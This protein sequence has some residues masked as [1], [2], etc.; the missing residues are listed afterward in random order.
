MAL[1]EEYRQA[2][3]KLTVSQVPIDSLWKAPSPGIIKINFDCAKLGDWGVGW[4]VAARDSGG[5]LLW[6]TM[7]QGIGLCGAEYEESR[8]CLLAC[9]EAV[10]RGMQCILL[11]GDCSNLITKLKNRSCPNTKLGLLI[12]H[13]LQVLSS[14]QFYD[15]VFVKRGGNKVAL[16]DPSPTCRSI[17]SKVG[18]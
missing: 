12:S 3:D 5:S 17:L 13:I 2:Q 1:V 4:G 14:V 6:S 7:R 16:S 8:S 18:R 11:E 10:R 9:E 15:F